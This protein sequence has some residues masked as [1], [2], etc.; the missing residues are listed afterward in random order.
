MKKITDFIVKGR[1]IFLAIFTVLAGT[2]LYLNTKVNINEDIMKYL[3]KTSETKIGYDIMN[4]DFSKQDTSVLNVMFKDLS[5]N[6]KEKTYNELKE[7]KGVSSVEYE[8]TEE[9][10]KD[11][12]TLYVVNVDDYSDSKTAE[13]VFNYINDNYKTAGMSGS[14]Y[15]EN[16]TILQLWI[17]VL[18]IACAMVI[19]ILLSE[20][21]LE[22]FLYLIAI[23]IAV[24]IN[25]GTNIMFDSVSSITDSITAILQLA[26]SMDYSIMLSNRYKQ[27]KETHN[28]K[29]EAMKEALYASF[30]S[31]SSSSITTVVGLLA[32][33]FMSFT[34]GRDL[35]IV[36]AKGVVLSLICIFFCLPAL[37]LIF[38][39]LIKKKKKKSIHFNLTKL[40][41]F[42][43]KTR[44]GQ[45]IAIIILFVTAFLLKGNVGITYTGSEQ[46]KVGQVFKE[47]NQIAIVYENKYEDIISS[48]CKELEKDEKIDQVLCYSNTINEKLAYNELNNKF[49]ELGQNTD[50]EDYLIKLIYYNY[51]TKDTNNKMTFNEFVSFIKTDIYTN[52]DLS[53]NLDDNSKANI[54]KLTN[55][56]TANNINQQRTISE[57]SNILDLEEQDAAKIL[58]YYNSQNLN[59]KIT[60]K[61]FVN[62]MLDE[63]ANDPEYSSS[64]DNET[65]E[66][67]EKLKPF[68][69]NNTINK[70]MT[71]DEISKTFGIDKSLVSQLF[72]FYRTTIDSNTK[73]T[74]NAFANLALSLKDNES[75]KNMFNEETIKSLT[76]LQILSDE[77][78]IN[79]KYNAQQLTA[80]LNSLGI[81]IDS[82][83][84]ELLYFY[85][86]YLENTPNTNM[87]LN[88]FANFLSVLKNN[89]TYESY[90]SS[91]DNDIINKLQTFSNNTLINT[92]VDYETM[93]NILSNY[94][95]D[96]ETIKTLY[97]YNYMLNNQVS[98]TEITL[99]EFANLALSLKDNETYKNMFTSEKVASLMKL[100]QLSN[101]ELTNIKLNAQTMSVT[102]NKPQQTI[103]NVYGQANV[104]EM[105]IS[106]FI[107][108]CGGINSQ[109]QD[110]KT[111]AI[112]IANQDTKM[113]FTNMASFVSMDSTT[114]ATLYSLNDAT[115]VTLNKTNK[116]SI[117]ELITF[118]L[119]RYTA[120]DSKITSSL[121]E[122]KIISLKQAQ[123]IMFISN[124]Q[125]SYEE[126]A[127]V[128]STLKPI[129][130]DQ[131]K[132]LY[133]LYNYQAL[134]KNDTKSVKEIINFINNH[135]TDEMIKNSLGNNNSMLLLA[136]NIVNNTN[137]KYNYKE[138][139]T[140]IGV[141]KNITKSIY[142][143][144]DYNH[145]NTSLSPLEFVNL[146][147]DNKDNKLLK[148]SI[149]KETLNTLNLV[150]TVMT[151]SL[152]NTKY[153]AYDIAKI[154]NT[155]SETIKLVLSLYDSKYL[156]E[157]NDI[158]LKEF[159]SIIVDD[160]A[161]NTK[162]AE[163]FTE[164][165]IKKL[166]TIKAIINASI[167]GTKYNPSELYASLSVLSD[168]LDENLVDLVFLYY[169]SV[170]EYNNEW[171]LTVE[172]FITYL[173]DDILKDKLFDDFIS[174]DK[175][176]TINKGYNKINNSKNLIVSDKYSRV[177]LNTKY[178]SENE[179]TY[180]FVEKLEK[181]LGDNEGIYI[182][183]NSPM[184]VEMSK[185][186]NDELNKITILTMIFIFVV[187]A[188]TFKDLIIPFVL[189]L[190]IQCA[191]YVTMSTIS[192]TGGTVYF[193]A[194]LIVQAILMGA[195][196]DYA[197][198]YTSYYRESRLK[199]GIK[200]SI[201][202]AYN[203]SIHT[204]LSSSLILMIVTLVVANFASAIAAKIC[205]TI[206]QGTFAAVLLI[207]LVLPGILAATDKLIC[208]KGYYKEIKTKKI[209]E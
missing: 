71:A 2:C 161:T 126:I 132:M 102:L 131:T 204:I 169:G 63:V 44:Y 29:I 183:G 185:T 120:N 199:M 46:D 133:S 180:E 24:F 167:N 56:T 200:D 51:Y 22:P 209:K 160:M 208:R 146:I 148:S 10:N 7:V 138:I 21:Y 43:Y 32:L 173:H 39:Y 81:N 59:T 92:K 68:I 25:K 176:D 139:A 96:N 20:S 80:V 79:T 207:L 115:V 97:I 130:S 203:R 194:L 168:D 147:L 201:V 83:K 121:T 45:L 90:V 85:S 140:L 119:D 23:G 57:I 155:D 125:Y 89:S 111:A 105:T 162:Y 19:L 112:I 106:E 198:V 75:Y 192:I 94:G 5:E 196:I 13:N 174:K 178:D 136:T 123:A 61:D 12:Y 60:I 95:F 100:Q 77:N 144:Y 188:I 87:T 8:N 182:V 64:L 107:N 127:N 129:S 74:L 109:D 193:I 171:N 82:N 73:M 142:G 58:L 189:V 101:K 1:Y 42:S 191:V 40:G 181:D 50:I 118:I 78:K 149:N 4:E 69:D 62:F 184:A 72:L 166:T 103:E 28:N 186:F 65:K 197:I 6:E 37:L 18:A 86:Y 158:S 47:T 17:V 154:L 53:S 175:R 206:S 41:N 84:T 15:D 165:Q 3:P 177:V 159:V 110:V 70:E 134:S 36:L 143:L 30:K 152:N 35:G 145:S 88:E 34:I 195:T 11:E 67:L 164:D 141:D 187:V 117:N 14:I 52:E 114:V 124:N 116:I 170:K 55:F 113:N 190:I 54:D 157:N 76:L 153:N 91:I 16:K 26:L 128:L 49:T 179:E 48:Y 98:N 38:D 93:Y 122:E 31:I 156:K 33:V 99:N 66:S 108:A 172:E 150:K 205:E 135:S 202:N 151:S 27:E 163:N 9:Y 104:T 137:T